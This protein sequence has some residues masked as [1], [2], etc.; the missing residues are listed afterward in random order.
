[1][2]THSRTASASFIL[3]IAPGLFLTGS[4]TG[5]EPWRG[6]LQLNCRAVELSVLAVD[7]PYYNNLPSVPDNA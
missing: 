7:R 1:M 3:M 6:N 5:L 2:D 4:G